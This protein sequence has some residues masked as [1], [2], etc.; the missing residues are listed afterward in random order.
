VSIISGAVLFNAVQLQADVYTGGFTV[1]LVDVIDVP[2]PIHIN[3]QTLVEI[4]IQP[5]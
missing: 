3:K 5:P 4:P 2:R 1:T